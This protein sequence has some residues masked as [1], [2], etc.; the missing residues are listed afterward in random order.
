[1]GKN[2][3]FKYS[4]DVWQPGILVPQL[5]RFM[6]A[7]RYG[8]AL[9]HKGVDVARVRS[10]AVSSLLDFDTSVQVVYNGYESVEDYYRDMSLAQLDKWRSVAVPLLALHARD[11]PIC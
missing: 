1:M 10:S 11:D 3:G 8:K 4:L 5:K 9:Q 6:T 7:G 2:M